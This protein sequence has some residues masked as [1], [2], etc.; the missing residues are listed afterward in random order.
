MFLYFKI[1]NVLRPDPNTF[2]WIAVSVAD[3]AAVNPNGIKILLAS[4][5]STFFIKDNPV[6]SHCPKSLPKNPPDCPN[7]NIS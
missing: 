3:S 1:I 4:G 5:L 2:L 6:F 7:P